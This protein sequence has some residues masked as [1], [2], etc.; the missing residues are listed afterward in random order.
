MG[1]VF[2]LF[3]TLPVFVPS[4]SETFRERAAWQ[5]VGDKGLRPRPEEVEQD[6]RSAARNGKRPPLQWFTH[7]TAGVP[8]T[9]WSS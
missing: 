5:G 6:K 3:R 7:A 8:R 1:W 2:D 4:Y 9:K